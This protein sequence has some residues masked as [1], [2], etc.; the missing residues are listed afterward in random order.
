[1]FLFSFPKKMLL[2]SLFHSNFLANMVAGAYYKLQCHFIWKLSNN[3]MPNETRFNVYMS[4]IPI[5]GRKSIV[6]NQL[7]YRVWIQCTEQK[8]CRSK[9]GF[10][11]Y[12]FLLF[13]SIDIYNWWWKTTISF[14]YDICL[15]SRANYYF[16]LYVCF[17]SLLVLVFF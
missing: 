13:C 2:L 17:F 16:F 11:T 12:I 15:L 4:V 5:L 10:F 1:M 8:N 6:I 14:F 3:I 9:C 7:Y